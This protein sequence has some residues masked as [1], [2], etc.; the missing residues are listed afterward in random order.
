M[1]GFLAAA[2]GAMLLVYY[3]PP[4]GPEQKL[5]EEDRGAPSNGATTPRQDRA[6]AAIHHSS[7]FP[8]CV[9]GKAHSSS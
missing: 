8:D 3:I 9:L 1:R 4:D 2:V 6:G 5:E 7:G